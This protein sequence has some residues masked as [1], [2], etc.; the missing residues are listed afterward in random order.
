MSEFE[1]GELFQQCKIGIEVMIDC[2][3]SYSIAERIGTEDEHQ[4]HEID[5]ADFKE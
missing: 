2:K 1:A 4:Y 5:S 3:L